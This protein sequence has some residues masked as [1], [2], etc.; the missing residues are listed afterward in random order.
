[1][2][3]EQ[4]SSGR[5]HKLKRF[6]YFGQLGSAFGLR[7]RSQSQAVPIASRALLTV[8]STR[9]TVGL[10]ASSDRLRGTHVLTRILIFLAL[11]S[12]AS[13]LH[14]QAEATATR[15]G[16]LQIGGGFSSAASDYSLSR[17]NGG[18][19]YVDFDFTHRFGV[20]GA[21]RFVQAGGNSTIYEK[22]YEIGGRYYRTYNKFAPYVRVSYG[23][24]VF[25]YPNNAA[26]LAYNLVAVGAGVDY[27][28]LP[29]LNVRGDFEYQ[30]WFGFPPGGLT[31]SM[32]TI[33]AAYHF[34]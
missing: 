9:P 19:A 4:I 31:P 6:Y 2:A 34:R 11:L 10:A 13:K 24:G 7:D 29:Y 30:D 22:T 25:N 15:A 17:F 1:M 18:S 16:D 23:R 12:G 3:S 14:A 20:E 8:T 5:H 26:N 33:G 27:K 28:V 21:F 32:F